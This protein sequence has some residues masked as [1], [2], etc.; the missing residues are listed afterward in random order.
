MMYAKHLWLA[1][2]LLALVAGGPN[3]SYASSKTRVT[4]T[5]SSSVAPLVLEIAKRYES[6]HPGVR[7][8]VQTGGSSRGLKDAR[9][10]LAD[11]GMVSRALQTAEQDLTAF[12]VAL[13]G[14]S[15][16]LHK[17]NRV[18]QLSHQQI[19]AIYTG[20]VSNWKAL[21]G[22]DRPI[23][24]VNKAAGRSTLAVMLN[25]FGL[26]NSQVKA[27]VVIG[28][29]Q[30]GIKT[31]AGNKG[32]IGYVSI[33]AAAYEETRGTPIKQLPMAGQPP[34]ATAVAKG[35]YP[36]TRPLNLVIKGEPSEL[37]QDF[38]QFAQSPAVR[39]LV[40]SLFLVAP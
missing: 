38:I 2:V 7:I 22:A 14:I 6:R 11:I 1:V 12:Q 10:G 32:A 36:L 16:I 17:S 19:I 34:S 9:L 21:G 28:D 8:D 33:G 30:Q 3:A 23:T 40:E 15:I 24:V 4:I 35:L 37:A 25:H 39:D 29:N 31:V 13:D 20:K 26:K 5:G 18:T 27:Q